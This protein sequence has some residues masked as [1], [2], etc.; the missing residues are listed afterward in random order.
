MAYGRRPI[1][2]WCKQRIPLDDLEMGEVEIVREVQRERR[3][4]WGPFSSETQWKE[5]ET[6][7]VRERRPFHRD[8]LREY[9]RENQTSLPVATTVAL[10][11]LVVVALVVL[12]LVGANGR[13]ALAF[14]GFY[15]GARPAGG[16]PDVSSTRAAHG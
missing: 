14:A 6:E 1:C 2:E 10:L 5:K 11:V 13:Y 3:S 8:C 16:P 7:K 15:C 9:E 12:Y 4:P